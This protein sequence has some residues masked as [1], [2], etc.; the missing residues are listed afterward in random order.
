MARSIKD[1][2]VNELKNGTLRQLLEYVRTDDTLNLELRGGEII[3]YYR[4]GAL[5]TVVQDSYTF[6]GLSKEYRQSDTFIV[7]SIENIE[8]YIPKAKHVIDV[9]VNTVKNHLGEKDI[10]Q[11]IARENNY[12]VNSLDTD[13][14]IIDTEYQ[15]FGRFD[16]VAIRWDSTSSSRKLTAISPLPTL[17]IFEVKQGYKSI[18][19]SSGMVSHINDFN[20]FICSDGV[21][22]FKTDML[23]V[24]KQKCRLGLI[25]GIDKYR[26][27]DINTVAKEIEF[28]F[29]LA[30]YKS[31]STQINKALKDI[32]ECKFIYANAMGYGLYARNII[33]EKQFTK[34]FL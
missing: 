28:V 22:D 11:Q 32:K 18:A 27:E 25:R 16:I 2:F 7:P 5:L 33:D 12:S 34:M 30:N 9:Y 26:Y 31:N 14:F 17:T 21:D 20:R 29:L 4:G 3:L 6:I 10:Q 15:N 13:Y 8:E 1:E 23:N 24:F 19:G